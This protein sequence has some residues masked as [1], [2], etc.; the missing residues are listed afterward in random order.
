MDLMGVQ[1]ILSIKASVTIDTMLYFDGDFDGHGDGDVTYKQSL[2]NMSKRGYS[3]LF[4][5]RSI[6]LQRLQRYKAL[7]GGDHPKEW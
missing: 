3:G 4:F 7:K 1:P 6:I 5:V 2:T